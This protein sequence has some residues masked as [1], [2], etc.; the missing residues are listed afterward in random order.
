MPYRQL[1]KLPAGFTPAGRPR[2]KPWGTA[3][4]ILVAEEAIGD[5]PFAVINADDYYGPQGFKLIYDYLTARRRRPLR[6]GHGGLSA[7][8]HGQRPTAT[9]PRCLRDRC[10]SQS[11]QRDRAHLHRPYDGGIHYSEDGGSTWTGPACRQRCINE[12]VGASPPAYVQ[13]AKAGF[14]RF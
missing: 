12:P 3:H 11:G 14:A 13:E 7:G 1:D 4:P 6:L 2:V 5:A 8:Q 9:Q 10:R